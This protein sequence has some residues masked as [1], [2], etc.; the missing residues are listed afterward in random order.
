M[1]PQFYNFIKLFEEN[2]SIN[3]ISSDLEYWNCD[4]ESK[5]DAIKFMIYK[6]YDLLV[7]RKGRKIIKKVL[8]KEEKISNISQDEIIPEALPVTELLDKFI[9]EPNKHYFLEY[10]SKIKK[11]V[12]IGD[13]QK[14][15]SRL[16][17]FGLI[18]NFEL[19]C[20]DFILKY[21]P[22]WQNSLDKEIYDKIEERYESLKE[23]DLDIDML[24]CS[25]LDDKIEII[26]KIEKFK[27]FC[28]VCERDEGDIRYILKKLKKLRNNLAHSNNMRADFEKWEDLLEAI[29]VCKTL[30]SEMR[31]CL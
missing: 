8:N 20:I 12:T 9:D 24:H 23:Q 7:I 2:V 28:L 4:S 26:K 15:P 14:G 29:R 13:L 3:S 17:F 1:K 27:D 31:K 19:I 11:I 6:N 30:T 5:K 22:D 18:M 21:A 16:L 10:K 25:F